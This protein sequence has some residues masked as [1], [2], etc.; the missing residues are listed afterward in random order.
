MPL[1]RLLLPLLLLAALPSAW[2]GAI[3]FATLGP[4][5]HIEVQVAAQG[6]FGRSCFELTFTR[7]TCTVVAVTQQWDEARRHFVEAARRPLATVPLGAGELAALDTLLAYYRSAHRSAC[8]TVEAV[9]VRKSRFLLP[10]LVERYEDGS[11]ER[12]GRPDLLSF[13][14]L[15]ARAVRAREAAGPAPAP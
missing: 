15:I 6:G 13:D 4:R 8:T 5:D 12:L 1:R 7:S 9:V 14:T 3:S 10:P 11:C 2:A